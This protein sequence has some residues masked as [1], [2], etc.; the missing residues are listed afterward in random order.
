MNLITETRADPTW[1]GRQQHPW[2][3]A[4]A[5]HAARST[6]IGGLATATEQI[7][8]RPPSGPEPWQLPKEYRTG[9]I[10]PVRQ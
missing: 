9:R 7:G 3:V 6:A 4:W 1:R 10:R 5:G 8:H 2:I